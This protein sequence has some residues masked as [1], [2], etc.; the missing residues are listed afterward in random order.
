MN[1]V[2]L[3]ST[4]HMQHVVVSACTWWQSKHHSSGCGRNTSAKR[5]LLLV[6]VLVTAFAV[7][8]ALDHR[9][10]AL[11]RHSGAC[12]TGLFWLVSRHGL[13]MGLLRIPMAPLGMEALKPLNQSRKMA[14]VLIFSPQPMSTQWC[15]AMRKNV[16]F[17][18]MSS[19][20]RTKVL[21]VSLMCAHPPGGLWCRTK[22]RSKPGLK[23]ARKQGC[24]RCCP[25]GCAVS[26]SNSSLLLMMNSFWHGTGP[27]W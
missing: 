18:T 4:P 24:M 7:M 21:W 1:S 9:F 6:V 12:V 14:M 8:V 25:P 20:L 15:G 2:T 10:N 11:G 22:K 13:V 26:V 19:G 3:A 27:A 17:Q 16:S 23:T 5:A